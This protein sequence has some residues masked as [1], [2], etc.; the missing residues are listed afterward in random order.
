MPKNLKDLID[1]QLGCTWK[2]KLDDM[3]QILSLSRL[4]A[5]IVLLIFASVLHA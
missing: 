2:I 1:D 3:S 4:E 5:R